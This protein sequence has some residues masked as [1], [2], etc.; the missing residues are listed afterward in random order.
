MRVSG[1]HEVQ[2]RFD[3]PRH[4]VDQMDVYAQAEY[5]SRSSWLRRLVQRAVTGAKP[6]IVEEQL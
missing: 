5:S 1:E 6:A 3:C 4:L 2:V